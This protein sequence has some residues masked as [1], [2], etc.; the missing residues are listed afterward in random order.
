MPKI[1]TA[2]VTLREGMAFDA[3]ASSGHSVA[4]NA[5][6]LEGESEQG[7]RPLEMLL[8][9]LGGC[10]GMDVISIL[11]KMRQEVTG[12]DVKV[13]GIR[14]DEHPKVYSDIVV[15]HTLKGRGIS[16]QM[17]RKAVDLS[18]NRYCPASA[19]LSMAANV[20]HRYRIVD[21]ETDAE[22]TGT[23]G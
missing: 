17:V 15:E 13:E 16:E 3:V 7:F 18:A 9:G 1:V 22:I 12:Y 14:V 8:V 5:G 20:V 4:L 10:T 6:G 19:M 11:R 21:A 2:T 23:L